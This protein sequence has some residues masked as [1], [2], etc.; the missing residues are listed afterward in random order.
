MKHIHPYLFK[1]T[2]HRHRA[3]QNS[4]TFKSKLMESLTRREQNK[5]VQAALA[6]PDEATIQQIL[7]RIK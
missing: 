1:N 6:L 7:K 2:C 5:P 4:R 3:T